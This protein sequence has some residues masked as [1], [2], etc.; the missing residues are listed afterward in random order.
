MICSRYVG[1]LI[2][3][4]RFC[5]ICLFNIECGVARHCHHGTGLPLDASD[6]RLSLSI[7]EAPRVEFLVG[8]VGIAELGIC[9]SLRTSR[10]YEIWCPN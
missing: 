2:H 10:D 6:F 3:L 7:N 4:F 8:Y 5:S 9:L 1:N